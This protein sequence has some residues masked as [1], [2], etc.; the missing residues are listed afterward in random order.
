LVN[1]SLKEIKVSTLNRCWRKLWPKVV[2]IQEKYVPKRG[3]QDTL[4]F[5]LL[6]EGD[7]QEL[8]ED[9]QINDESLFDIAVNE[10]NNSKSE[11]TACHTLCG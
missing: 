2:K 9:E 6:V 10:A 1:L 7:L 3:F 8:F 5:A 4:N 11:T